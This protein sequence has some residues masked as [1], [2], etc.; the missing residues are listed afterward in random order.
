MAELGSVYS[1][2]TR[3]LLAV[4]QPNVVMSCTLVFIALI[5]SPVYRVFFRSQGCHMA[6]RTKR[7]LAFTE[8][9]IIVTVSPIYLKNTFNFLTRQYGLIRKEFRCRKSDGLR[10]VLEY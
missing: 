1:R 7:V 5:L 4:F 9:E 10:G 3:K 8:K 6:M 2:A